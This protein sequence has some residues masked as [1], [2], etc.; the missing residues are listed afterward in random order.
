ME[1]T[2]AKPQIIQTVSNLGNIKQGKIKNF[3]NSLMTPKIVFV[4]LIV[5]LVVEGIWG[6]RTLLTP[7]SS[8]PPQENRTGSAVDTRIEGGQIILSSEKQGYP[9]GE[10]VAVDVTIETDDKETAGADVILKFDPN[11]LKP[12]TKFF[13]P[14]T[15]FNDYPGVRV[16]LEKGLVFASGIATTD[17]G[18]NG[19][20]L[21]GTFYFTP[22]KIGSTKVDVLFTKGLTTDSNIIDK[23]SAAD[24]LSTVKSLDLTIQ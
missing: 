5:V 18:F 6:I 14:G 2:S 19:D 13:E 11:L 21:F 23:E 3:L 24:I 8:N 12:S 1:N 4:I 16:D 22:Q 7:L 9:T 10:Q 20:A 15:I 17:T